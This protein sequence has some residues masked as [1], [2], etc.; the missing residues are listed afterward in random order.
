MRYSLLI[1]ISLLLVSPL[2][3]APFDDV[4]NVAG[5]TQRDTPVAIDS[6][7]WL[8][9]GTAAVDYNNDSCW[10]DIFV[11]GDGG[12]PNALYHNNGDDTFQEIA[13]KAGIANTPNARGCVW[14]DYDNDGWRDLYVTCDGPNF[15][16]ANNGDCT[17]TDVSEQAGV[18]DDLHGTSI[19]VTDYDHDG[20]LDI[21]VANWGRPASLLVFDPA[22]RT[23]RLY[24]NLGD[25][26]FE[27]VAETAGVADDGI[28]WGSNLL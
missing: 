14:F 16:F 8:G 10:M 19:A 15:L 18:A 7:T 26:T 4:S 28:A 2:F 21:Y 24:R 6:G 13:E 17:F 9:P 22:P 3:A 12:L 11:I 23:N 1:I 27:E 5:V 20:W 25:G